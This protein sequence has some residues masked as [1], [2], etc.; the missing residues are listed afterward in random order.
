MSTDNANGMPRQRRRLTL[1]EQARL[2]GVRPIESLDD[3]A[4]DVFSS[5]E[6]LEEFLAY[7]YANRRAGL[8]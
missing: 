8:V 7:T 1:E 4:R 5:D 3:L 2:K 6:E